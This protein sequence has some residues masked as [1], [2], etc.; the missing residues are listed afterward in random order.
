[1]ADDATTMQLSR[2]LTCG[3]EA[4]H[5]SDEWETV[6]APP[7]GTMTQ[8]PACGSTDVHGGR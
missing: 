7:L 1:M 8:C 2:C 6:D 5:G 3:F 4:D